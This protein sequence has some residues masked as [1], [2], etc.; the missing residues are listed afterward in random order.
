MILKSYEVKKNPE[1][2][3]KKN[4]FLLYGENFGL[5]KDIKEFIT[6]K[7]RGD[8]KDF[9]TLVFYENEIIDNEEVFFNALHS[10]SLFGS[11]KVVTIYEATDKFFK[12]IDTIFE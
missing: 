6:K 11:K 4:F 12:K 9:E 2:L 5:K 10:G 1:S 7:I 8:N 3:L